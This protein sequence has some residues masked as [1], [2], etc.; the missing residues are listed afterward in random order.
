MKRI[1]AQ[2]KKELTQIS[3]D[4]LALTLALVLPLIM[5]SLLGVSI[6]LT[7]TN[8]AVVVQDLDQSPMSIKYIDTFRASLTFHVDAYPVSEQ[9]WKA[10]ERGKARAALVIPEH[11]QEKIQRGQNVQ[12]QVLIDAT[13]ANTANIMRANMAVISQAFLNSIS[14]TKLQPP[15]NAQLRLWYN[16]SRNS[17]QY[18]GPA[19]IG[20]VVMLF[21]ALLG[22]LAMSREGEQHT[23]LQVYVSGISAHEFLL[24]KILGYYVIA[25]I[26]WILAT[27]LA[28]LLFGLHLAGDPSPLIVGTIIYLFTA[29]SFG[30]MIGAAIP[31]QAAAIQATQLMGFMLSFLL[32]GFI[33]PVSNIPLSLRWISALV[34]ARYYIEL[35]RDAF[36]R[37]GGWSAIWYAPTMLALLGAFFFF[38]G[39]RRMRRMQ[40][41]L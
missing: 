34:P 33:F 40:V 39:W 28:T 23:I 41:N 32:S 2:A 27:T 3:R 26:E 7:V 6:S 15:I 16:P 24:G 18:I 9:P 22:A 30:V 38:M 21:P 17:Q 25:L 5:L 8:L 12:V 19:V 10:L 37:G 11:F 4:R 13:D 14:N 20:L 1:I 29:V 36:V 31:N 35:S